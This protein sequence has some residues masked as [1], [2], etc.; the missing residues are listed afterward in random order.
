CHAPASR[1]ELEVRDFVARLVSDREFAGIFRIGV[2]WRTVAA[3]E[4][5][6][7]RRRSCK[8]QQSGFQVSARPVLRLRTWGTPVLAK[9][10]LLSSLMRKTALSCS[11]VAARASRHPSTLPS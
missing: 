3:L 4:D 7:L 11:A 10:T 1:R 8:A 5:E 6:A 2:I 9:T